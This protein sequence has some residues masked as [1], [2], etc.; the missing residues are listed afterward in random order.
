MSILKFKYLKWTLLIMIH[1]YLDQMWKVKDSKLTD[2]GNKYTTTG[3]WTLTEVSG[4]SSSF[5]LNNIRA[6]QRTVSRPVSTITV[7][8]FKAR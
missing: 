7:V 6:S 2:E 8:E 4:S 1:T 5:Y 3:T